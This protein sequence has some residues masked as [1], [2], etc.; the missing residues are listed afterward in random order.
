MYSI[1]FSRPIY[2]IYL[3]F[4]ILYCDAFCFID[5][6]ITILNKFYF[7]NRNNSRCINYIKTLT[8]FDASS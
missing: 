7:K 8:M 5:F 4:F 2:P 3:F 1:S 6:Q